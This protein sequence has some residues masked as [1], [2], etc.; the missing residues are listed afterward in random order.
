MSTHEDWEKAR[1]KRDCAAV[2]IAR[3]VLVSRSPSAQDITD[4]ALS[5]EEMERITKELDDEQ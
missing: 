3:A 5:D 2:S 1:A 4:F